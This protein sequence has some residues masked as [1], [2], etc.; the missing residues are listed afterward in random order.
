MRQATDRDTASAFCMAQA[1]LLLEKD[2]PELL[3]LLRVA[4]GALKEVRNLGW[5]RYSARHDQRPVL[6]MSRTT[7]DDGL[8]VLE[9]HGRRATARLW[10]EP[11]DSLPWRVS[12]AAVRQAPASCCLRFRDACQAARFAAGYYPQEGR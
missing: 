11:G 12:T 7:L 9:Y 8:R 4:H 1:A 2:D 3:R 6:E 5:A 10:R